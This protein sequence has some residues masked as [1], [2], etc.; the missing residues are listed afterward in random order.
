MNHLKN[1]TK[2]YSNKVILRVKELAVKYSENNTI[3]DAITKLQ[4]E[5]KVPQEHRPILKEEE[6]KQMEIISLQQKEMEI[7]ESLALQQLKITKKTLYQVTDYNGN[8]NKDVVF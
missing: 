2:E 8:A 4:D 7:F 5:L 6:M 1:I 3:G